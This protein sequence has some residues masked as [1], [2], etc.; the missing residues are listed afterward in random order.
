MNLTVFFN[1]MHYLVCD[2]LLNNGFIIN[3]G[4]QSSYLNLD[5]EQ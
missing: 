4:E 5:I 2:D 1:Y 3:F